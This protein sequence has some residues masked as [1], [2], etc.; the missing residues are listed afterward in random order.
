MSGT[1]GVGVKISNVYTL[2]SVF[3]YLH[4]CKSLKSFLAF[5]IY[6]L[7]IGALPKN[8][9]WQGHRREDA[10]QAAFAVLVVFVFLYFHIY[11]YL[12]LY[13][14]SYLCIYL[15]IILAGQ[16]PHR[17]AALQAVS[18]IHTPILTGDKTG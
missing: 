12:Y 18:H 16:G 17:E 4:I 9:E 15:T 11:L 13:L 14:Y 6:L 8:R 1:G 5:V 10:L 3:V 2:Q 7:P